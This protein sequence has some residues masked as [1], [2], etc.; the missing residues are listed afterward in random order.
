MRFPISWENQR[1][2]GLFVFFHKDSWMPSSLEGTQQSSSFCLFWASL[3]ARHPCRHSMQDRAARRIFSVFFLVVQFRKCCK[4][5]SCPRPC[6]LYLLD[7]W[8]ISVGSV[9]REENRAREQACHHFP[10]YFLG[11]RCPI[12]QPLLL[13]GVEGQQAFKN[14]SE[15]SCKTVWDISLLQNFLS[16]SIMIMLSFGFNSKR[17]AGR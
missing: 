8:K 2:L 6:L 16:L 15:M 4:E 13:F 3:L 14:V 5:Q 1:R 7:L 10:G 9:E 17:F 11:A 12:L